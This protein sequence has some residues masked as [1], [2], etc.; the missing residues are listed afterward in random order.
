MKQEKRL[1]PN[2]LDRGRT[3]L[4]PL[5]AL[6]YP[7][8]CPLCGAVLE[9]TAWNAA[10]CRS[11]VLEAEHLRHVP[12]RLPATE[13]CFYAVNTCAAA[14]Y[15]AGSVRHSILLCKENGNPW[16]AR[17]LADL[18]AVLIFGAQPARAP[19]YRPVYENLS[20]IPLYSAI[21]PVPP[22]IKKNRAENMPLLLAQRL[23]RILHIP[24]IQPLCLTR[25]VLPQKSLDQQ[26]RLA[27]VKDA[28]VCRT[29]TDLSGMRLML[30]DDVI[31]TGATISAC[32][33][34]LLE[35]GAVSV[36]GVCVA[37]S[38]LMPKQQAAGKAK[39]NK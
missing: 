12:P 33:K 11:C 5:L 9:Q 10:V 1:P 32:A 14:F 26:K 4:E 18:M 39:E 3:V 22:R 6:A 27:N 16:Y 7:R 23:G 25:Q 34:A 29:G 28:Y 2:W 36:D 31:T 20:G 19:G 15:Y 13:H 8:H 37:A 30:L 38:E 35:G 24:V 21:V 17:E